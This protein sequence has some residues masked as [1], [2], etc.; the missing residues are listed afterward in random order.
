MKICIIT[1]RFP[2]PENAGDVLRINGVARYLKKK[3]HTLVLV[4][5]VDTATPDIHDAENLYDVIYTIKRKPWVSTINSFRFLFVGKPIQCGYY[6]SR[7]FLKILRLAVKKEVPDLYICHLLRTVPYIKKLHL[8]NQTIVEMTDAL[9]KT[10]SMA[11]K[12]E[13]FSIKKTIYNY[14][15]SLIKKYEQYVIEYYPKVVLVSQSDVNYLKSGLIKN[16]TN[17]LAVYT[18]GV[19]VMS[20]IPEKYDNKKICFVGNM[21]TLQNQEAAIHFVKHIF[22]LI[23]DKIPDASFHIVGAQPTDKIKS[24]ASNNVIVTGFVE[25]ICGYINDSCVAVA[26]VHIAAGIQ[27]KVLVSMGCGIPVIMSSLISNAIPE[28]KNEENCYII[29]DDNDFANACVEFMQKSNLRLAVSENGY[30]MVK[31]YYSW[32]SKLDGYEMMPNV[33]SRIQTN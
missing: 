7:A 19:E 9:S 5:F 16:K 29:D 17:S 33:A 30:E 13:G 32:D 28:L 1:P 31:N 6:Y 15:R 25:D 27:N 23:L 20:R 22:P 18:N 12:S 4:S 26:P 2:F 11:Q 14:E 8:E 3:G 10:Y 21:R 24:L